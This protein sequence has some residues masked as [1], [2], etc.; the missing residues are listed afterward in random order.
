MEVLNKVLKKRET[1]RT[2]GVFK[3]IHTPL[4]V[5]QLI[6]FLRLQRNYHVTRLDFIVLTAGNM[7]QGASLLKQFTSS[8]I[9]PILV[10]VYPKVI[11]K[12]LSRLNRYGLI[13]QQE[14]KKRCKRYQITDKGKACILAFVQYYNS[15]LVS[16]QW[17][18]EN[19][20]G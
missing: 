11:Y 8:D 13:A 18:H 10:G 12:C 15:S 2:Y 7:A 17:S 20:K 5:F 19:S 4:L 6:S 3:E 9:L 14:R 16:F 1:F